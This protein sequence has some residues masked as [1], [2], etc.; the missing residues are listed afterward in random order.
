MICYLSL[1]NGPSTD[2]GD[3]GNRTPVRE[4]LSKAFYTFSYR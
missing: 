2:G 4:T 3:G 1:R